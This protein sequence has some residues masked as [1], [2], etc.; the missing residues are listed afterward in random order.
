M[1]GNMFSDALAY[2]ATAKLMD[3][4]GKNK[5]KRNEDRMYATSRAWADA[6]NAPPHE[7]VIEITGLAHTN[8]EALIDKIA[9]P[10]RTTEE[11]QRL[12]EYHTNRATQS[13][14][15]E[16][17]KVYKWADGW[18]DVLAYTYFKKIGYEYYNQSRCISEGAPNR[19]VFIW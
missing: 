16:C 19:G 11:W 14:L 13:G 3:V 17:R 7:M 12:N 15:I 9:G 2:M 1:I 6:H 8:Y 10:D 5:A 4:Y 18:W